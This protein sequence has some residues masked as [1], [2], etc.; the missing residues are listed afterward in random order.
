MAVDS[1]MLT[2]ADWDRIGDGGEGDA[3]TWTA[4]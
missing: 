2:L 3:G 1:S 4:W